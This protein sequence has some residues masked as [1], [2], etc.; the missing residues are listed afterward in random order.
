MAKLIRTAVA[1]EDVLPNTLRLAA[2]AAKHKALDIRAYDVR[3]LTLIA[4]CFL[5]C[6]ASSEPQVKAIFNSVKEG[7]GEIGLKPIHTEGTPR[8][9]WLVLDY[10]TIIFH[11]F[12]EETRDFY[13][14][15]GLWGDA[16]QIELDID[17]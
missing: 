15:D 12:R 4:D 2:L 8:A 3:G 10:G 5:I 17:E 1:D 16:P 6:S 14:L 7:M 11:I 9:G 13:D